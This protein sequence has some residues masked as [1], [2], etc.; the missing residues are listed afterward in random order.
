MTQY[1]RGM[2]SCGLGLFLSTSS[3]VLRPKC[4][5]F[6][7]QLIQQKAVLQS[8]IWINLHIT[9]PGLFNKQMSIVISISVKAAQCKKQAVSVLKCRLNKVKMA[10]QN[11]ELRL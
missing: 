2:S 9:E 3:T 11:R 10:L 7:K 1:G 8:F 4:V 6:F 5:A